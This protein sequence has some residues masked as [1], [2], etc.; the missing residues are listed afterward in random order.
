MTDIEKVESW[1][2]DDGLSFL[3]N[4]NSRRGCLVSPEERFV[5]DKLAQGYKME[6][7]VNSSITQFGKTP[8]TYIATTLEKLKTIGEPVGGTAIKSRFFRFLPRS[9]IILTT[10][11]A[12]KW[13]LVPFILLSGLLSALVVRWGYEQ[14]FSR[15]MVV[16]FAVSYIFAHFSLLIS[17][18]L[19][20]SYVLRFYDREPFCKFR[21]FFGIPYIDWDFSLYE[22]LPR[23][24]RI[25][26]HLLGLL[27]LFFML[28][29][30]C[31]VGYLIADVGTV[32]LFLFFSLLALRPFG[33]SEVEGILEELLGLAEISRNT[34]FY[35]KNRLLRSIFKPSSVSVSEPR[36]IFYLCLQLVWFVLLLLFLSYFL[37]PNL[38]IVFLN[39]FVNEAIA[40]ALLSALLIVACLASC[41]WVL[42]TSVSFFARLATPAPSVLRR[43]FGKEKIGKGDIETL[44]EY[45]RAIPI[46][47]E[48]SQHEVEELLSNSLIWRYKKGDNI[49]RQGDMGRDFFIILEGLVDVIKEDELG[50]ETRVATLKPKDAFGELALLYNVGRTATCRAATDVRVLS[51]S[52]D[53]FLRFASRFRDTGKKIEEVLRISEV[54]RKNPLFDE[55]S[56]RT[57]YN[58]I[59]KSR[60][61]TFKKGETIIREGDA[62]SDLYIIKEGLANVKVG[63]SKLA[64]LGKGEIFGEIAIIKGIRRTA[65]VMAAEDSTVLA[66]PAERFWEIVKDDVIFGA[67]LEKISEARRPDVKMS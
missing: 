12:H 65:T 9:F 31:V 5:F 24:Q 55:I 35:S 56:G 16:S 7:I 27:G 18:L 13:F 42:V 64:T 20:S 60:V 40:S 39:S 4:V 46:F 53:V 25:N 33:N 62:P 51:I 45:V 41:V 32:Y 37:L 30:S 8:F 52:S 61:Q 1:R 48:L 38:Y 15:G 63:E 11:L 26:L 6:D 54:L 36:V 3:W 14:V 10:F 49:V 43:I 17:S 23:S 21:M 22:A 44:A 66:L 34:F 19:K 28:S 57:I 50:V 29:V 47:S 59:S 58:I 2:R 67:M